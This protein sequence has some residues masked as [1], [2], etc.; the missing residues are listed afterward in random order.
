MTDTLLRSKRVSIPA[1]Y[2]VSCPLTG[3]VNTAPR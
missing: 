2:S 1:Y 3:A